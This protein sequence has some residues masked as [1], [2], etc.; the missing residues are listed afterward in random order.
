VLDWQSFIKRQ[1]ELGCCEQCG[2]P[3]NQLRPIEK[4]LDIAIFN[5][6][7]MH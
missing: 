3:L 1:G 6:S 5:F 7:I 2:K 4:E